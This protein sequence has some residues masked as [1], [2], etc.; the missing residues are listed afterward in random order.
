V[1]EHPAHSAAW[2]EFGLPRPGRNGWSGQ[3]GADGFATEISL[4]AYGHPARKP[5]W[6]Y[7]YRAKLVSLDWTDPLDV[8]GVSDLGAGGTRHRG[9]E[10]REHSRGVQYADASRTPPAFRDVLL[11]MARSVA[12]REAKQP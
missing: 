5:T 8:A 11:D 12:L 4:S 10:W 1:L 3:L 6:L 2:R 7:S 9:D